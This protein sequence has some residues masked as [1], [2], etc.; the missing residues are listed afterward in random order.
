MK[1]KGQNARL[2]LGA[3]SS[4]K[5]PIAHATDCTVHIGVQ[6]EDDTDKDVT[7]DWQRAIATGKSFDISATFDF[8]NATDAGAVTLADVIGYLGT[9]MYFDFAP[10][11]G[12]Q[13]R[14]EGTAIVGGKVIISDL[15]I[16]STNRQKVTA[17][18]QAVGNGPLT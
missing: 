18:V 16:Q 2:F 13:N 11:S 14:T 12:T 5:K 4:G 9:E 3:S 17:S 7:D 10:A 6:T 1:V 8:D 15:N